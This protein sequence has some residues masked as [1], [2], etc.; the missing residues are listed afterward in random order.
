[1]KR[2]SPPS[3]YA[4]ACYW[5][6]LNLRDAFP[7]LSDIVPVTFVLDLGEPSCFAC[8][9]YCEHWDK[10][11]A[12]TKRWNKSGLQKAHIIAHSQGGT[13]EVSNYILLCSK[14]HEDAPMTLD[15]F[16]MVRWC[17]TRDSFAKKRLDGITR[18]FGKVGLTLND[19]PDLKGFKP[20]LQSRVGLHAGKLSAASIAA[21][22]R[23]YLADPILN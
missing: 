1:M 3:S 20:F 4:I 6:A 9:H 15:P 22:L 7:S 16:D 5:A 8:G 10:P 17:A 13:N 12:E 14:C 18:E 21:A 11:A 23:A 2:P 19:F